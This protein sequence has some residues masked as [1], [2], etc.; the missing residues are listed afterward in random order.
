MII[1]VDIDHTICDVDAGPDYLDYSGA[2]PW[3][4]NI[5]KI[6]HLYDDGHVIVYWTARGS[7]T[8]QDW[9]ELTEKQFEEWGV[10]YHKLILKKPLYNIFIDDRNINTDDFFNDF[11]K[12]RNEYLTKID[13]NIVDW[14]KENNN[15]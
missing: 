1:Y 4:S 12:Y 3:H 13:D 5:N 14:Q 2:M 6:N 9:R 15:Q 7:G 11:N 10:K 8:G